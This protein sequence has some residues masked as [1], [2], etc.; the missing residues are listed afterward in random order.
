MVEVKDA[1]IR[2]YG[3]TVGDMITGDCSGAYRRV[4]LIMCGEPN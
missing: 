2:L 3:K 1:F 4:L